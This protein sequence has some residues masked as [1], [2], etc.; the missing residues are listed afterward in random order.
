LQ[1]II[2][3]EIKTKRGKGIVEKLYFTDLN[4]LMVK[5]R[6]D[7]VWVNYRIESLPEIKS[8]VEEFLNYYE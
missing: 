5:V 6:Y 1:K 8:K 7:K 2:G 3:S 4:I